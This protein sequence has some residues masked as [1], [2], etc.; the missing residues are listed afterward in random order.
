MSLNEVNI[1]WL[2]MGCDFG[3]L[4]IKLGEERLKNIQK[5]MC[6]SWMPKTSKGTF[7]DGYVCVS[8]T[9]QFGR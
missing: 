2:N 1:V 6:F 5:I 3:T 7:H 8:Y 4:F 9:Q